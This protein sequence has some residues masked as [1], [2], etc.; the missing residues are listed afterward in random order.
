[1]SQIKSCY[2]FPEIQKVAETVLIIIQIQNNN[3]MMWQ[4]KWRIF[5]KKTPALA[6]ISLYVTFPFYHYIPMRK[7]DIRI[8]RQ[9]HMSP[10][11]VPS[12]SIS[13][14]AFP[15]KSRGKSNLSVYFFN[16][17]HNQS[18]GKQNLYKDVIVY[19]LKCTNL[20]FK[21]TIL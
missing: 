16:V 6:H 21:K 7:F 1:M 17:C 15:V 18:Y 19:F 14:L 11:F 3:D 9:T 10:V 2:V 13:L 5:Q 4:K 20:L 8:C 12:S